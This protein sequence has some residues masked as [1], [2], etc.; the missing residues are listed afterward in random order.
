MENA[1]TG[2]HEGRA[3]VAKVFDKMM[4]RRVSE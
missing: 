3:G 2:G 4:E 1:G